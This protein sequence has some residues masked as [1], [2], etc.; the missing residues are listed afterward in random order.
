L[1]PSTSE[2]ALADRNLAIDDCVTR[3]DAVGLAQYLNDD[4]RY[5]HSNGMTQTKQEY[6]D[7]AGRRT[8]PPWRKLSETF[9]EIHGDVAVTRGNIDVIYEDKRP[10]LCVRYVRVWRLVGGLWMAISQ[11]T[12]PAT[13]R[14]PE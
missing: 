12:L 10:T 1:D 2:Q 14:K 6:V 3:A 11:R 8:D 9:I 4:F 7:A 13:D 5:T